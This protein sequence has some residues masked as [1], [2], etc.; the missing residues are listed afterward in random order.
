ME[1]SNPSP[2][3]VADY[4]NDDTKQLATVVGGIALGAYVLMHPRVL[5][6]A[7]VFGLAELVRQQAPFTVSI[8]S[9]KS[10][11]AKSEEM[12]QG[13]AVVTIA[14]E[15]SAVYQYWRDLNNAPKFMAGVEEVRVVSETVAVWKMRP[16]QGKSF[17]WV[18]ETT[19]DIPDKKIGWKVIGSD[20]MSGSG[21]VQF[22]N[23]LKQ[24]TTEVLLNQ[25]VQFVVN[26]TGS[27]TQSL[28]ERQLHETLRRL[29]QILETGEIATTEG[30][31]AGNRTFASRIAHDYVRPVLIPS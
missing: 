29:K 13:R 1:L 24:G 26:L 10:D 20:V 9:L 19:E 2:Q 30:Q 25:E 12:I 17:S 28:V 18:G 15:P 7:L 6:F 8:P 16:I 3:R 22:R 31:P 4:W 21:A 5:K 23:G 27:F 11:K 14:C